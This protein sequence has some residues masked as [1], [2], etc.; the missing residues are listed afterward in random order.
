LIF[1]LHDFIQLLSI[2]V[3]VDLL[4]LGFVGRELAAATIGYLD[5]VLELLVVDIERIHWGVLLSTGRC[6]HC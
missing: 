4:L 2:E 6:V 1:L 5:R 3:F